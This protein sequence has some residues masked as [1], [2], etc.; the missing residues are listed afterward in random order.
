MSVSLL[1][2]LEGQLDDRTMRSIAGELGVAPEQAQSAVEAALPLLIGALGR[3][4]SEPQ[5]ARELHDALARDHAGVD[6][7]DLLGGLGGMLSRSGGGSGSSSG[8]VRSIGEAILGHIFGQR[9]GRAEQ[10]LGRVTGLGSTNA[11]R[12]MSILA[13]IVMAY[14]A[15]RMTQQRMGPNDLGQVLGQERS[16][17]G[18]QGGTGGG[19]LGAVLDRDGDGDTDFADLAGLGGSLFGGTRR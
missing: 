4:A 2:E 1:H 15:K 11:R 8:G 3:N 7:G 19:L 18:R 13:P 5:G 16:R 17:I 12:L 14:L 9:G 10:G 6:L